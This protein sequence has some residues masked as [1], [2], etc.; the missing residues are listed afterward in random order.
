MKDTFCPKCGEFIGDPSGLDECPLCGVSF[1][2]N[3]D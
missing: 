1:V 3:N 2:E